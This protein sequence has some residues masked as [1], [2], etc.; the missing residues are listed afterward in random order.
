VTALLLI[1]ALL[2]PPGVHYQGTVG[3]G[4]VQW[5]PPTIIRDTGASSFPI[6]ATSQT[7]ATTTA[8]FST[9]AAST[10]IVVAIGNANFDGANGAI[11]S[12]AWSGGSGCSTAFTKQ[13]EFTNSGWENG[14]VWTAACSSQV[15]SKAIVVTQTANVASQVTTVAVDALTNTNG[16]PI[17][18]SGG[19]AGSGSTARSATL[20]GV[21]SQ[22]W[23]YVGA[24]SE[25]CPVS[26]VTGTTELSENNNSGA[27]TCAA[28]G[29]NTVGNSPTSVGWSGSATYSAVAALE[30]KAP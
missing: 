27:N 9:S 29:V 8:T 6:L 1:L 24:S 3:T 2:A 17:G 25:T 7:Q 26:P 18:T 20:S 16:S 11:S 14:S 13:V 19:Q 12:V 30:I 5:V 10:L 23:V 21:A 22:S 4:A 28:V 15:T